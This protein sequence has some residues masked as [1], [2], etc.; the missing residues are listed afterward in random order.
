LGQANEYFSITSILSPL[1]SSS[2][3]LTF[4]AFQHGSNGFFLKNYAPNQGLELSFNSS[5]LVQRPTPPWYK[6]AKIC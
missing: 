1:S 2:T 5:K 3:I 6:H 4:K